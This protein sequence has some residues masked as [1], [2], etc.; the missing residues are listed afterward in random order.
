MDWSGCN[1]NCQYGHP[2]STSLNFEV[3]AVI[4]SART[5][6][7]LMEAFENDITKSTLVTKRKKYEQRSLLIRNQGTVLQ[8]ALACAVIGRADS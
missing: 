6:E 7:R 4:Y 2:Q 3:N 1:G 8:A 5:T